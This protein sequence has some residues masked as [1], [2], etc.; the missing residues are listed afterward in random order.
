[1]DYAYKMQKQDRLQSII[2]AQYPHLKKEA[3]D[4]ILK[5][6]LEPKEPE[7][8]DQ[9]KIE[10]DRVRFRQMLGMPQPTIRVRRHRHR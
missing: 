6:Y 1:M 2:S 4:N 8:I 10:D 7:P 9:K 3:K 5:S